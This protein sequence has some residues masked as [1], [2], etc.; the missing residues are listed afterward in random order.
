MTLFWPFDE[1]RGR[2]TLCRRSVFLEDRPILYVMHDADGDWQFLDGAPVPEDEQP[3]LVRLED[4]YRHD[5]TIASLADLPV[6]WGAERAA[7]GTAWVREPLDD[8]G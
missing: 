1:P 4:V 5:P 2:A 3:M 7:P 8:E 6:G